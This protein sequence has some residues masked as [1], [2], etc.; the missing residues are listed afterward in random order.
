[1]H[2]AMLPVLLTVGAIAAP[3]D[4][5]TVV[6]HVAPHGCDDWSGARAKSRRHGGDGPVATLARA[7]ELARQARRQAPDAR[8]EVHIQDGC[9]VLPETLVFTA[10]DAGTAHAP[11][12]YRAAPKAKPILSGAL[13]LRD[14]RVTTINGLRAWQTDW[15]ASVRAIRQLFASDRRCPRTRLPKEGFYRVASLPDATTDQTPWHQGST[16][17]GYH[18]GDLDPNWS[19]LGD[20]ELVALH[21]W[22]NSRLPIAHIDASSRIVHFTKRSVFRL[23]DDNLAV[24]Q[25]ETRSRYWVENV[26]EA[27]DTPGQ[28]YADRATQ[29]LTYLPRDGEEPE[30][31]TLYAAILPLLVHFAPG[32][33]HIHLA[34]LTLAHQEWMYGDPQTLEYKDWHYGPEGSGSPQADVFVPGA[35]VL[36]GVEGCRL[37]NCEVR[38]IA[39]YAVELREGCVG[40]TISQCRFTDLGAG[41][42]KVGHRSRATVIADTVILGG[43]RL[44]PS[45]VG[46]LILDSGD[47]TVIHNEI[48]DLYYSG[49]SVGWTWGYGPSNAARNIIEYNH[50]H[51]IGQ[52]LL[53]DMGGIYCLGV[54]PGTRLRFNRIHDVQAY[55]YGGWGLYTD[56]GSSGVLLENNLV[57]RTK[58]AGFHQHYGRENVVRNNIFAFGGEAGVMRT[59][60]EEHVSFVFE[61]NIVVSDNG[62]LV[63]G[64][65]FRRDSALFINNVY[66]V[67]GSATPQFA[68]MDFDAWKAQGSDYLSVLADPLFID[69]AHDKYTLRADS[70]AFALGFLPFDVSTV[71]PRKQ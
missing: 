34:G 6:I 52:G 69:V 44:F 42:V 5:A 7:Q 24:G 22:S 23:S 27:L 66:H 17:A 59:R 68:G 4:V 20:V 41:G 13:P 25:V 19:N 40:N 43:G 21:L 2:D 30:T 32:A 15:P 9:Y 45:A 53:S 65:N 47:N 48:G 16:M 49:V 67:I 63:S 58:S 33:H 35:V 70:P 14:W 61:R 64:G 56:E 51:T 8:I 60:A 38:Q 62:N 36:E 3:Q 29:T 10:E 50:I 39:G 37:E 71:G 28:W 57:Y 18:D 26:K 31:T 11:T 55:G 46:V 12:V 54:A 1:M